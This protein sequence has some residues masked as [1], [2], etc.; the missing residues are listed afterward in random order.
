MLNKKHSKCGGTFVEVNLYGD[1][2]CDKC[3]E[4]TER[5]I[6]NKD[7]NIKRLEAENNRLRD[8]ISEMQSRLDKINSLAYK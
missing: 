3:G 4:G 2:F 8:T 6:Y 5:Y 1:M 7:E